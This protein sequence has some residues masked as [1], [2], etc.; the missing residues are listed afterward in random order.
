M[1]SYIFKLYCQDE[2]AI[3]LVIEKIKECTQRHAPHRKYGF[4][5][6]SNNVIDFYL[7]ITNELTLREESLIY[8]GVSQIPGVGIINNEFV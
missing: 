3:N 6:R 5:K 2:G 7:I 8:A 1:Y 4:A